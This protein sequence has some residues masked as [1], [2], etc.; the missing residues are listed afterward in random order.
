MRIIHDLICI[1]SSKKNPGMLDSH[2]A[3][4]TEVSTGSVICPSKLYG[5]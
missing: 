1:S 4:E 3:E 2:S 5:K